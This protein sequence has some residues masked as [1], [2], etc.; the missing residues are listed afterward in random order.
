MS[1]VT[2]TVVAALCVAARAQ[3][4]PPPA[5]NAPTNYNP[6]SGTLTV[7]L[8]Q[9][10]ACQTSAG[11][12]EEVPIGACVGVFEGVKLWCNETTMTSETYNSFRACNSSDVNSTFTQPMN[13][14][15]SSELQPGYFVMYTFCKPNTTQN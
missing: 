6:P 12:S 8:F 9:D 13:E 1:A 11:P 15:V 3:P 2:Q 10:D 5:T 4:A 7:S 14:C